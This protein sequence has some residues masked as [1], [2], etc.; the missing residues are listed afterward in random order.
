MNKI[1]QSDNFF[2]DN[3]NHSFWQRKFGPTL[4][5][6]L[7]FFVE[8]VQII[9]ISAAI[10]IP[11]RYFLI[12]PFYVRGASMEPSFYD[13]EYLI[14]DEISYRFR[15]PQR[16]EIVVFRYPL[17]TSEF[18][19]KRVVA[20]PGDTIEIS[21]QKIRIY[22]EDHLN[23]VLLDE[24]SYLF[25]EPTP[26]HQKRTLNQDEYFVL[27]DN[28]DASLDSRSFGP[29]TKQDMIG[30]VWIRGLPVSRIHVFDIPDYNL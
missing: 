17:D 8:I 9:I 23:G 18:F 16:G 15:E 13:N 14:I 3:G 22:N 10:I 4:G 12:Q 7:A 25:E 20:I 6:V 21:D 27:G 28:R 24:T 30:R 1:H 2:E 26:G 5:A 29:I 11:I 19:I